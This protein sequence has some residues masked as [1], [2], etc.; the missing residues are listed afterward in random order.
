MNRFASFFAGS[1]LLAGCGG[2]SSSPPSPPTVRGTAASGAPIA[3]ATVTLKDRNGT[4]RTATTSATGTYSI[5]VSGLTTPFLVKVDHPITLA[6]YYSVGT[7]AGVVNVTPLTDLIVEEFYSVQGLDAATEFAT[8]NAASV[9]PTAD[10]VA[11]IANVVENI[12][13]LWLTQKGVNPDTF[14]LITTSFT[15]NGT[16]ADAVLDLTTVT[17][18]AGPDTV[19]VTD[20][21]TSTTSTVTP[22]SANSTLTADT[23]TTNASGTST[24][25]QTTIVPTTTP[26]QQAVDGVQAAMTQFASTVNSKGANLADTDLLPYTDVNLLDEGRDRAWWTGEIASDLRG[27]NLSNM[28]IDI[29]HSYDDVTKIIDVTLGITISQGTI[30]RRE[31]VRF[32]FRQ[33]SVTL[34]WLIYGNREI[35]SH[36]IE[37]EM[38]IEMSGPPTGTV[39][40]KSINVDVRAL[41]NS[42]TTVEI[43]DSTGT[44]F[45]NTPVPKSAQTEL[46]EFYPTPAGPPTQILRDTFFANSGP[47]ANFPAPGTVFTLT[48]TPA[49]GPAV[50]YSVVSQGNTTEQTTVT[51]PTGHTL[52][53]AN[54][55]GTLTAAWTMPT[56]FALSR[57][58]TG[59]NVLSA[60]FSQFVDA[61]EFITTASTGATYNLPATLSGEAVTNVTLNVSYD[62]PSGER[63]M[64]LYNFQ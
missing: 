15:A 48:I 31:S 33:D 60:S 21:T 30:S 11:I 18:A 63:I 14:D 58:D 61:N 57:L 54:L 45:N 47:L 25:T 1:L 51:T 10:Q 34:Q 38:R 6:S 36:S 7:Q 49:T 53:D 64:I 62:G 2:G 17:K 23:T 52:A 40:S 55:G 37:V 19:D 29:V 22:D 12:V 59:C 16:G 41:Q 4:S 9:V 24:S 3:A 8:L 42:V 20:G 46:V 56:T 44:I 28:T 39:A 26:Q 43:T 50:N 27:K 35:V 32:S 5:D 13:S